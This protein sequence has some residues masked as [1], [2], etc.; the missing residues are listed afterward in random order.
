M[1]VPAA[2]PEQYRTAIQKAMRTFERGPLT[3]WAFR[4]LLIYIQEEVRFADETR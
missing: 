1:E 4:V 2:T 3:K